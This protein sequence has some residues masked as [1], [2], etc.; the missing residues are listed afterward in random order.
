MESFVGYRQVNLFD[1]VDAVIFPMA[2]FYPTL[3]PA[4]TVKMDIFELE[5]APDAAPEE[6]VFPLVL[7]SHGSGGTPLLYRTLALY[8]ASNGFVVGMPQHPFNNWRDNSLEGQAGNLVNRPRHIQ[9]AIDW[10]FDEKHTFTLGDNFAIIGH[11][12]GGCTALTMAGGVPTSKETTEQIRKI[13]V[14]HDSRL[15]A[16]VLL[17]PATTWFG[18]KGALSK[19][20]VPVLMYIGD[21][22]ERTPYDPHALVVLDGPPDKTKVRCKIIEKAGHFSFLSPFPT[23]MT[24]ESYPPSQDPPGFDRPRFLD[25]LN[26]EVLD[27]LSQ[28][29][30]IP[31]LWNTETRENGA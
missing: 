7:I 5:I 13:E 2:I 4:T 28:N 30:E 29:L 17:A 22:D 21:Q 3:I 14:K 9:R 25:E 23:R 10:F 16:L 18:A 19:V 6:G 31:S 26:A 24:R 15:K 11:S 8:L 12:M 27:F 20:D 1:E